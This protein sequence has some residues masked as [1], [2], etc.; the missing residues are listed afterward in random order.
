MSTSKIDAGEELTWLL[1]ANVSN[2]A[3]RSGACV[4]EGGG[5]GEALP[6]VVWQSD[7]LPTPW[8]PGA[9]GGQAGS[10]CEHQPCGAWWGSHEHGFESHLP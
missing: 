3:L 6:C 9:Q 4:S 10:P 1:G 2:A 5:S 7:G 8:Q